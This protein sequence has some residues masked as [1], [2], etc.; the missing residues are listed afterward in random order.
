MGLVHLDREGALRRLREL[1]TRDWYI[2]RFNGLPLLIDF[3]MVGGGVRMRE[4]IGY[5]YD[6]FIVRY[7]HGSSEYFYDVASLKATSS[8]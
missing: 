3:A 5:G 6:A 4:A 8:T 2:Q 7:Q 1:A